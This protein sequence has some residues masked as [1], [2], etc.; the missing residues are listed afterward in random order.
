MCTTMFF[1]YPMDSFVCRHVLVVLFFRGRR[2]HEGDDAAVLA[3]KDRRVAITLIV[4]FAC[5]IPALLVDN[6]GSVLAITGTIGAS[7]L[8]YIGPGLIYMAVYG[9][10]FLDKVDEIWG[11]SSSFVVEAEHEKDVESSRLLMTSTQPQAGTKHG[12]SQSTLENVM[13]GVAWYVLLM[14]IWCFVSDMG[15]KK[16]KLYQEKESLKSPHMNRLGKCEPMPQLELQNVPPPRQHHRPRS[17]SFGDA[18]SLVPS[19]SQPNLGPKMLPYGA[20][21]S[22]GNKAIGAAILAKKQSEGNLAKKKYQEDDVET[23]ID[24][25]PTWYDFCIAIFFIAFGITALRCGMISILM[26]N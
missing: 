23:D 24:I 12:K 4:Y 6:V 1:V 8:A 7:C 5:L 18:Q 2:A 25:P 22:G 9:G 15:Q 21:V 11:S 19:S 10:E 14:P 20:I 16:L 3:R 26:T 13:K 17:G